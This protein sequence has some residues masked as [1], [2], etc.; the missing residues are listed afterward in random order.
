MT[1]REKEYHETLKNF[2]DAYEIMQLKMRRALVEMSP[3]KRK[4]SLEEFSDEDLDWF[5]NIAAPQH[6]DYEICQAVKDIIDQRKKEKL[7]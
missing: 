3:E 4:E 7:D 6:E 1:N 5:C 2:D